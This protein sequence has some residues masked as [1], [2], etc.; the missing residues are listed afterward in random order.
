[1]TIEQ[2]QERKQQEALINKMYG[3]EPK[4]REVKERKHRDGNP[5]RE[6]LERGAAAK[7]R[8]LAKAM[9][10]EENPFT[11]ADL[12]LVDKNKLLKAI[13]AF[14]TKT[15]LTLSYTDQIGKVLNRSNFKTTEYNAETEYAFYTEVLQERFTEWTVEQDAA[16]DGELY[17]HVRS[18]HDVH[19]YVALPR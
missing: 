11:T 8:I 13:K 6:L 9:A 7:T 14:Y 17:L 19:Y 10:G 3:I 2:K 18:K 12:E 1:M 4:I 16:Y 5:V 15:A